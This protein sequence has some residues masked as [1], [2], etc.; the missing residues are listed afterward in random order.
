MCWGH[1]LWARPLSRSRAEGAGSLAAMTS[2]GTRLA[3]GVIGAKGRMGAEV[4]RAVSA[5]DDLDLVSAIDVGDRVA[6]LTAAGAQVA[7]DFTHPDAVMA[8]L[9][10]LIGAG[11]HVVVGTTGFD[12]ERLDTVRGWLADRPGVG[13]VIAP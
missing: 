8:T 1:A 2:P 13:V 5:A 6:D 12:E 9:R 10:E 7:V 4:C 11:I 3:V